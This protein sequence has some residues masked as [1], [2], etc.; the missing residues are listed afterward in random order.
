MAERQVGLQLRAP[1]VENP[2][3]EP[4]LLGGELLAFLAR[5]GNRRGDGRTHDDEIGDLYLDVAR[6]H[7]RV[8][9][10]L[11]PEGDASAHEHDRLRA[12]GRGR[13]QQ[14]GGRPPR[15]ERELHEPGAIAEIH[16]QHAAEVAPA[17]Y[18][19]T[20]PH[21]ATHVFAR[22]RAGAMRAERGRPVRHAT[23]ASVITPK[24]SAGVGAASNRPRSD[25]LRTSRASR[26][27]ALTC[28]PAQRSGPTSMKKSL[29][30]CPSIAS[31]A[32]GSGV[33]PHTTARS[34]TL[35]ARPCG[36]ATPNP[37][38]VL[39]SAS[40]SSTADTTSSSSPPAVSTSSWDSSRTIPRLSRDC[41]GM[42]TRSGVSSSL[43]STRIPGGT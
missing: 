19:A 29:T 17:M 27:S 30:G 13:L 43:S 8:V 37:M 41:R 1:E 32:T 9:G 33:V 6:R 35:G 7:R 2:V 5:H 36:I 34:G 38:P 14:R 40:R 22:E 3:A 31:N 28:W 4:K 21:L 25:S 23:S 20:Q 39:S 11:G 42:R 15:V 18:P 16:E 24:K 10:G 12:Q 26:P